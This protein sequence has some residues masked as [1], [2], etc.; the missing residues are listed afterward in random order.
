MRVLFDHQIMDAQVR[1]GVSRYFY[2]LGSTLQDEGL[3]TV[4]LPRIHTD[5]EYFGPF[6][7]G[8]GCER[9]SRLIRT[10][11]AWHLAPREIERVWRRTKARLNRR[12]SIEALEKQDFD[13]FHPTY[14]DPY[15]LSHLRGKPFVLTIF[16]MIH[17]I[18]PEHFNP[19]DPTRER[20]ALLARSAARIIAISAATRA[21]IIQY[22]DVNPEKVEVIRLA[23]SLAGESEATPVP[24]SYLLYVG[25]RGR[26]KN[27]KTF[28]AAFANLTA[29]RPDLHLVCV[30]PKNFSD[31]ELEWIQELGLEGRCR[32]IS[33]DD[34]QLCHLYRNAA[35]FVYPS[36]YEGFGLPI[37][38]AFAAD[39]PVALS[40]ASCFP[41]VAGDAAAYFD[42]S[43]VLSIAGVLERVLA[44]EALRRDLIRRGQERLKRFSWHDTAART[45]AVYEKALAG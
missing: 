27:F 3:A 39:C 10:M 12:A 45:V 6:L 24:E 13:V 32:N 41:E 8:L 16:D 4:R 5:N 21:D 17:E 40:N 38:E 25:A 14:Y 37:L 36:L 9:S 35:L 44:D 7:A 23:C 19:Q 18:Y 15:F 31:A 1:G 28:L 11:R 29:A 30:D 34:R 33:A 22:L 20:K 42:P 2:R 43:D 26:Y